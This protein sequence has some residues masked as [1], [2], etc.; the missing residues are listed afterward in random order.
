M[1]QIELSYGLE[2]EVLLSLAK[3]LHQKSTIQTKAA[4]QK[5]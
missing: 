1:S 3:V 5:D 4:F 2:V